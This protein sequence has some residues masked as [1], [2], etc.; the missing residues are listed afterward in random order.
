MYYS[1]YRIEFEAFKKISRLMDVKLFK[2]AFELIDKYY[3][4]DNVEY[5]PHSDMGEAYPYL[6]SFCNKLAYMNPHENSISGNIFEDN[7]KFVMYKYIYSSK[8]SDEALKKLETLTGVKIELFYEG[9]DPDTGEIVVTPRKDFDVYNKIK[10]SFPEDKP[11]DYNNLYGIKCD[12][13]KLVPD[14]VWRTE[15]KLLLN[16]VSVDNVIV[17]ADY[18]NNNIFNFRQ[19]NVNHFILNEGIVYVNN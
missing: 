9:P 10:I 15:G 14:L 18:Y 8:G 7:E 5:L 11:I 6:D 4:S 1:G 3:E 19:S 13:I 12:V 17:T 16:N 2:T